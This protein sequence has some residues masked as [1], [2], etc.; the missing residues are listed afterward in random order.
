MR[1]VR[2]EAGRPGCPAVSCPALLYRPRPGEGAAVQRTSGRRR[3]RAAGQH[4]GGRTKDPSVPLA[5]DRAV[6]AYR[7]NEPW[8]TGGGC[9]CVWVGCGATQPLRNPFSPPPPGLLLP[10][11]LLP[12]LPRAS[13]SSSAPQPQPSPLL[14]LSPCRRRRRR[15]LP[16][17]VV[18]PGA[19][20]A[21]ARN[22]PPAPPLPL[23]L[24][25]RWEL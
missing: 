24:R 16:V 17:T 11:L 19:A 13:A 2:Q 7:G 5:H 12:P 4:R 25:D 15:R 10:R 22:G 6:P 9:L 18:P 3:G 20:T 14:L 1:F 8:G 21:A 23:P